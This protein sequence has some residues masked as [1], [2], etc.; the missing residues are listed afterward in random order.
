VLASADHCVGPKLSFSP[1]ATHS[2]R[3]CR[4]SFIEFSLQLYFRHSLHQVTPYR[5]RTLRLCK[6]SAPFSN[7]STIFST[8]HSQ[9]FTAPI[10]ELRRDIGMKSH[11]ERQFL[12]PLVIPKGKT[13]PIRARPSHIRP[14]PH[15]S[16]SSPNAATTTTTTDTTTTSAAAAKSHHH[17]HHHHQRL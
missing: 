3:L 13:S 16:R 6:H 7:L 4:S 2:T 10:P 5:I 1:Q 14:T 17:H 11:N 8:S 12:A 15:S 9:V